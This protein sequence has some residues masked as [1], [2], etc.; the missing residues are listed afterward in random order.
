MRIKYL[1][2]L[3]CVLGV[4]CLP[5]GPH[6][7]LSG[8]QQ[9][10]PPGGPQDGLSGWTHNHQTGGPQDGLP[11][12]DDDVY[13][14]IMDIEDFPHLKMVSLL[15]RY[16]KLKQCPDINPNPGPGPGRPS[17]KALINFNN[18]LESCDYIR[19][20]CK[21]PELKANVNILAKAL[22]EMSGETEC[23]STQTDEITDVV[24]DL[25]KSMSSGDISYI[26]CNLWSQIDGDDQVRIIFMFYNHLQYEEQCDVFS[27][28]GDA[29]NQEI[30]EESLKSERRTEDITLFDLKAA[31]KEEFYE[32]CEKRLKCFLD[33]LTAKKK[34]ENDNINFKSN[35]IENICKARNSKF[36]SEVGLKEHMVSYLASGKSRHSSQVFSKQGGKGTRPLLERILKTSENICKFSPPEKTTLFFSF[37]NIQKLLKSYRIGGNNQSKPLGIVVCSIM[38]LLPDGE[39][40]E[41]DI[42]FSHENCPA[43]WYT[44]YKYD[45]EKDIFVEKIDSNILKKCVKLDISEDTILT[46]F[47]E[48]DLKDAIDFVSNDVN[49][50][51]QDSVDIQTRASIAKRRKLCTSGHINDNVK[52]NRTVCDRKQCKS[53]LKLGNDDHVN[54]VEKESVKEEINREELRAKRYMNVPCIVNEHSPKELAVG[55]LAVNPNTQERISKVLDD[56]LEAAQIKK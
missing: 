3:F 9:H 18:P 28:L 48:N 47:F 34:S 55:A 32:K 56:I 46:E 12:A 50:D 16:D 14:I 2:W 21:N 38:C 54:L 27:F 40:K 49:D 11:V 39:D 17:V 53:K 13:C 30:Y 8:Q 23:S 26:I 20:L 44:E 52:S 5:G 4:A 51:L 7:G 41:C 19:D 37:D 1:I 43:N 33:A 31:S 29:L 15:R 10:P 6:D 42:Q 24:C 35:V 45:E 22:L 36:V 25:P